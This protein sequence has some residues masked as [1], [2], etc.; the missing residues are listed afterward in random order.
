VNMK[1]EPIACKITADIFKTYIKYHIDNINYQELESR[2]SPVYID[3]FTKAM[4]HYLRDTENKGDSQNVKG[5]NWYKQTAYYQKHR[6]KF[7]PEITPIDVT[8]F[9]NKIKKVSLFDVNQNSLMLE[10][11][12]K[13]NPADFYLID[14]WAT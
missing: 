9:K 6:E 4:Y 10:D 13:N 2:Y 1:D 14:F 12:V 8:E 5:F 11:I 7:E 3:L